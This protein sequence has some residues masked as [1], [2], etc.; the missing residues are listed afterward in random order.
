MAGIDRGGEP[1]PHLYLSDVVLAFGRTVAL[2]AISLDVPAGSILGLIGRNGA[3]KTTAIRLLAGLLAPDA[4]IV[5]V[6]GA[7][8]VQARHQVMRSTGFLLDEL[9]LFS[10]LTA[11]ETLAWLADAYGLSRNEGARRTAALLGFFGLSEFRDHVADDL[12][13][14]MQKRLALAAAMVHSPSALVL[15]EPFESLDPLMV[16]R[17]KDFLRVYAQSGGTVMLS[18]HLVD[19]V[20][21]LCDRVA[22]LEAGVVCAAGPTADALASLDGQLPRRTLEELYLSV[23]P[24]GEVADLEWMLGSGPSE[25]ERRGPR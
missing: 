8:P 22:I 4:G 25:A 5:R 20:E 18:S 11:G 1:L 10:Y 6:G 17:L 21:E 24:P 19:V 9:A 3:G 7:D 2:D 16:R 15:D 13:T 12:S 23:V 14:G